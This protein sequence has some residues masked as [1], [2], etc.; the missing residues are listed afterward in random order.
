MT[1]GQFT[2]Q[3]VGFSHPPTIKPIQRTPLSIVEWH[4]V[5]CPAPIG[6][7]NGCAVPP[8]TNGK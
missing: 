6:K 8:P 2:I 3:A 4:R 7:C 5:K 1:G